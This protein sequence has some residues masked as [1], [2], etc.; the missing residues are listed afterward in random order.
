MLC[1]DEDV[2]RRRALDELLRAVEVQPDDFDL[3]SFD[4]QYSAPA[5]WHASAGTAPF[6]AA[7]RVVIV[8]H[9]LRADI[10]RAKMVSFSKL[11]ESSLLILIADEEGGS[12]E[13][14]AK[15][16]KSGEAWKKLVTTSGGAVLEFKV[17]PGA[18]K[19][20]VKEEAVKLGKKLAPKALE[21]LVEMTGSSI[22]RAFEELEKVCLCSGSEEII[23]ERDIRAVVVPTREWNIFVMVDS[24]LGNRVP[25]AF[26]QLRIL[27]GNSAKAEDAAYRQILPMLSR[28]LRLMWQA[29]V[30]IDAGCRADNAPD[31]VRQCFPS[32][33]SLASEAPYR[34]GQVMS[35]ARK[36]T[37][38]QITAGFQIVNDA[39]SRLKGI[40]PG[41]SGLE[42][43]E[44]MILELARAMSPNAV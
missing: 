31:S 9:V 7:R 16:G 21:L 32:R 40:L 30:C 13:R 37:L 39:D 42:T 23:T 4:A 5:D 12:E 26:N 2:L 10:D 6:L 18:T 34:Q 33:P 1:G 22:S 44:R 27:I 29:R 36:V 43:L 11:P 8:R 35:Q 17:D 38:A 28:A 20:A 19:E 41:F 24:V 3:E 15:A 25:D 14:V